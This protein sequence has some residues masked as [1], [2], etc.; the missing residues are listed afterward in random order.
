M[1]SLTRGPSCRARAIR[2]A[3]LLPGAIQ[4]DVLHA[5]HAVWH[6]LLLHTM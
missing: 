6:G 2:C 3:A 4:K 1:Y 5:V